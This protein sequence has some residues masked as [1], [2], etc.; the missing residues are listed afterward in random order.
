MRLKSGQTPSATPFT[1]IKY[2]DAIPKMWWSGRS[3]SERSDA[4]IW[5]TL[6]PDSANDSI[7]ASASSAPRGTVVVPL[8]KT[9]VATAGDPS[10]SVR[11]GPGLSQSE[12]AS[13]VCPPSMKLSAASELNPTRRMFGMRRA[14]SSALSPWSDE[15]ASVFAST[16]ASRSH[17]SSAER[18]TSSGT[19]HEPERRHAAWATIHW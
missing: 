13:S 17:I 7:A 3:I 12:N 15:W 14:T 4:P 6:L 18:F 11:C 10:S 5:N 9:I 16:K 1:S 2:V 8:V 19:A